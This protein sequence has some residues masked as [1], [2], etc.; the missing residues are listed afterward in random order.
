MREPF[1][2][3]WAG[4]KARR[5]ARTAKAKTSQKRAAEAEAGGSTALNSF[6]CIKDRA[7]S[8]HI[9]S[10]LLGLPGLVQAELLCCSPASMAEI[11]RGSQKS[12]V[13]EALAL[14]IRCMAPATSCEP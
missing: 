10:C 1:C 6:R 3:L 11:T 7:T 2:L 12:D 4:A 8:D 5:H 9:V 14:Q 13:A